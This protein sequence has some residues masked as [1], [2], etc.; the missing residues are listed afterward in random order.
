MNVKEICAME[1]LDS[2]ANPTVRTTVKLY[3]GSEHSASVPS[4][5]SR[6]AGEAY[7]LRDRDY[8]RY[9]GKGVLA[10][11]AA[12]NDVIAPVLV[13]R[14][15]DPTE[16]DSLM[17]ALDGSKNKSN[18]G[19]NAILSVSLAIARAAAYVHKLPLYK[20]VGGVGAARMP[21]PMMNVL[22]GG[23]HAR[24]SIDVQEFMILPIGASSFADAVRMGCEVYHSLGTLLSEDGYLT[25]VGDEGGYAPNLSSDREALAFLVKAIE[26]AG[27]R[28]GEDVCL[29]LDVAASEW[30]R[31]GV[32]HTPKEGRNMS[33]AELAEY[34]AS[35][36]S[37]FPI[38]SVED[39]AADSDTEGW[40]M[41]RERIR[42]P[43]IMLV[44]DDLFTTDP[45]RIRWGASLGLANSVLI[46]PNQIG[47]LSECVE[48][49]RASRDIGYKYILSHRSGETEDT[50]IADIAVGV[51]SHFIKT[52]APARAERTAKYNRLMEIERELFCP[53]YGF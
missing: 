36:V 6:G 25:G 21:V 12:V 51:G 53:E 31:D 17:I 49:V 22:N 43:G 48:A 30:Y 15:P 3:D 28:A 37:E 41:L 11:V 33:R 34:I 32:Y 16:A 29:A 52:G 4:G 1:I 20:Y 8:N 39:G 27:Y 38:I 35:L 23:A 42:E 24:N 50:S 40:R 14:K 47:T 46:K 10:A 26:R 9:G 5:A 19:A 2:R 44:G 13:D 7:E 45:E 18:L